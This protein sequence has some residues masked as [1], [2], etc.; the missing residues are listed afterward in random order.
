MASKLQGMFGGGEKDD[1]GGASDAAS[2][3][4]GLFGGA[5]DTETAKSSAKDF[6]NRVQTGAPHEGFSQQEA[7]SH[8]ATASKH[9]SPDQ[10]KS[11]TRKAVANMDDASRADFAKMLQERMGGVD[12]SATA[13]AAAG[14]DSVDDITNMLG[15]L[16]GGGGG[17]LGGMLGGLLG[18][19]S[20][21]SSGG[22]GLGDVL[23]G[24]LGGGG[25]SGT[26][27]A[28][29]TNSGGGI[30]DLLGGI[31]GSTAGI[32]ALG[33]IAAMVL[34]ELMGGKD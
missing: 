22:G 10:L 27:K 29:D 4:S 33:G 26:N 28:V 21:G 13:G 17:D 6:I 8:L 12:R 32:G 20:T 31:F 9:V 14:G 3:L 23:G 5:G 11:A 18:G 30:D 7:L 19:G 24:L 15:G 34:G 1:S 2:S 16:L 25:D